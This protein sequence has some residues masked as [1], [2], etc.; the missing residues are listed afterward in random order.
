MTNLSLQPAE[1][2]EQARRVGN[3]I[4]WIG[5]I[6]E[7]LGRYATARSALQFIFIKGG[8]IVRQKKNGKKK[9][10]GICFRNSKDQDQRNL[11]LAGRRGQVAEHAM[12]QP[13]RH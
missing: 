13:H 7:Q 6:H 11:K 1:L 4:P 8:K 5:T 10:S 2:S 9:V 12:Q 3:F